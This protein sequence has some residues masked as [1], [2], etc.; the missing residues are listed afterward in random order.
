MASNIRINYIVFEIL[1]N[2]FLLKWIGVILCYAG[3]VVFLCALISFG[4]AWRIGIDE[5]H[6]DELVTTGIFAV[7]RNPIFLFMDMYFMG[8]LLIY[9]NIL[10]IV[11]TLCAIVG[12][13]FQIIREEKFLL[14]RFGDKYAEYKRK[15]R[16]Y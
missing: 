3:I 13:H 5:T 4:K 16:R 15:T 14:N 7:S 6:S 12:I 11:A 1:F 9:P 2:V 8:I 10:F